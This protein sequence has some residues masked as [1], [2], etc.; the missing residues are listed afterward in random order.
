[1]INILPPSQQSESKYLKI[2]N[3]HRYIITGMFLGLLLFYLLKSCSFGS[4][5][6]DY[7]IGVDTKWKELSLSG[8]ERNVSALTNDLLGLIAKEEHI[9]IHTIIAPDLLEAL[10]DGTVSAIATS[11][12][13]NHSYE[14]R[15]LFSDP[16]FLTGPVLIISS[17]VPIQ[18][19]NEKR[20]KI[21]AVGNHSSMLQSLQKDPSIEVK[22]YDSIV[23]AL[24]DL[25]EKRI[26]GAVFPAISAHTY[27][28]NY[29]K[30][31]LKVVTLP[32]TEEGIRIMTLKTEA[33]KS[34]IAHFNSGLAKIK[35]E[36]NYQKLLEH[37]HLADVEQ[38]N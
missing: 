16:Y 35:Q 10:E 31:E 34:L 27:V 38:I 36:G 20:K 8:K 28:D 17:A 13:P 21:I 37:W 24:G 15:F 11:L 3:R 23:S 18:G 14:N 32:L 25:K 30:G 6:E 5:I 1:M 4:F 22:I 33:G 12:Q 2:S 9:Y 26:D 7:T 19:L 29:Y